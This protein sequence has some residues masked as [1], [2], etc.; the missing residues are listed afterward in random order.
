MRWC[1]LCVMSLALVAGCGDDDATPLTDGGT[2]GDAGADASVATDAGPP[3][4][5]VVRFRVTDGTPPIV[6]DVPFPSD[7]FRT[8]P[9]GTLPDDIG[10]LTNLGPRVRSPFMQH[11]FAGLDGFGRTTGAMFLVDSADPI[12]PATIVP[13]STVRLFDV[14]PT[15]PTVGDE[16]GCGAEYFDGMHI[17]AADPELVVLAPGRKYAVVLTT[18]VHTTTGAPLG[19]D[20][21]FVPI[22]DGDAAARATPAGMLYGAAV[23]VLAAHGVTATSIAGLAVFTTQT[24]HRVMRQMRDALVAGDYGPAPQLDMSPASAPAPLHVARFG[25]TAHAGWTA[26]LDEWLGD[27]PND[28]MGRDLPGF[29]NVTAGSASVGHDA[30][31]AVLTATMVSPDM[32]R[33]FASTALPDDGTIAFDASGHAIVQD[34]MHR[35]PVTIA[36]P[37]TPMPAGG[38]P[39]VMW[40]H[41]NPSGRA[42][43]LGIANEL[44]RAGIATAAVEGPGFGLRATGELDEGNLFGGSYRGPDGM[45]DVPASA[46]WTIENFGGAVNSVRAT[47]NTRQELL[48]YCQL[49]RLLARADLDLA[50]AADE[51]AGVAPRLDPTKIAWVGGSW[52]GTEGTMLAAIE[53]EIGAFVLNVGNGSQLRGAA[54]S[55]AQV[56]SLDPRALLIGLPGSS[57]A[58]WTRHHPSAVLLQMT[59]DAV[60]PA[61]FAWDVTH[62]ASGPGPS[63][64]MIEVAYD[65]T[66]WSSGTELVAREMGLPRIDASPVTVPMLATVA[67]PVSG[68]AGGK[69]RALMIQTIG[70]HFGNLLIH[71]GERA[72]ETPFPPITPL[73]GGRRVTVREP[74]VATQRSVVH[75]LQTAFAGGPPEIDVTGMETWF[76]FDDDGWTD[77]EER[78][79]GVD[80]F[81]PASHPAGAP[82]HPRDVGF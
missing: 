65:E 42:T 69:T 59:H 66:V 12:D 75:F 2:S 14:D 4:P 29:S 72:T 50:S 81:D 62:P 5:P 23:D 67:A 48:D 41:G 53:P 37:A 71:T 25:R 6:L 7:L 39:V 27:A 8:G 54:E 19:A 34:P 68:N 13:G 64:Y 76:D 49:R 22:R 26:T 33:P 32:R 40:G 78:T 79:A 35:I 70:T 30:I 52:G 16:L 55:P 74:V 61:A 3:A 17:L 20:R 44:A 46:N 73:P 15:S 36:L 60:D 18:G 9:G 77:D 80:P 47:D 11:A 24:R 58:P 38:Y 51:Y 10:A 21:D 56:A 45:E 82:T 28:A 1:A 43:L 63:V 57:A 31:A